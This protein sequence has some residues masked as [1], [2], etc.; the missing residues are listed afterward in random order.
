MCVLLGW[1]IIW[2]M[3]VYQLVVEY[4]VALRNTVLMNIN[5]C[6]LAFIEGLRQSDENFYRSVVIV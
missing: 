6:V 3:N 4:I 5:T 1:T 2:M